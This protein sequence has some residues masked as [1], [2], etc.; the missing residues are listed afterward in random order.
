MYSEKTRTWLT[1]EQINAILQQEANAEA[2]RQRQQF[3]AQRRP[4]PPPEMDLIEWEQP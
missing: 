3:A 2:V 1:R 4:A